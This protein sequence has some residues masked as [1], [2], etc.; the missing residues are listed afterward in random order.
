M[1]RFP[2]IR[3]KDDPEEYFSSLENCLRI[4]GMD[5]DDCKLPLYTQLND[6]YRCMVM[7]METDP[8]YTF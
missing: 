6:T 7:D 3:D 5:E 2:V 1:V 4:A 8:N